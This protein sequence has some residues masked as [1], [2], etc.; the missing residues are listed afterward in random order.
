MGITFSGI[1]SG[2]DTGAIIE[3]FVYSEKAPIRAMEAQK[4]DYNSQ[5]TSIRDLNSKM[6]ALQKTVEGMSSIG[7]FL[8]YSAAYSEEDAMD[9]SANGDASPGTYKVQVDRLAQAERDYSTATYADKT[10]KGAAGAGTLSITVGSG[11]AVDIPVTGE[12]TLED[13]V[14]AINGSEANVSAS[15][16]FDGTAYRMQIAGKE[17]GDPL[18]AGFTVSESGTLGFGFTEYQ[19]AQTAR[20]YVDDMEIISD[21]NTFEDVLTGV[22]IN[23]RETTDSPFQM[24][25]KSDNEEIKSTLE[26]FVK[27]YNEILTMVN[28]DT[29]SNGSLR[30]LRMQMGT[31]IASAIG[32][33]GGTYTALSQIG[34]STSTDGTLKLDSDDLEDALARDTRGVA[35]LFAGSDDGT[36]SGMGTL[37]DDFIDKYVSSVDGVLKSQQSGLQRMISRLDDSILQAEERITSYEDS[38][39]AKFTAMEISMNQLQSQMSY[40]SSM[41]F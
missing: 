34:I 20:I 30:S 15:L 9:V 16:L 18:D 29:T 8:S 6:Q 40:M 4:K 25:I 31:M 41:G 26:G 35:Q 10:L 1:S 37:L 23:V 2:I 19:S 12:M 39:T 38:L 17:T 13:I 28:N 24:E 22:T 14:N 33:V 3:S 27:S 11:S 32:D 21:S 36:V 7:D 5:L